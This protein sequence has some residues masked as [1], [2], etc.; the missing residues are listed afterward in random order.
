VWSVG[1]ILAPMRVEFPVVPFMLPSVGLFALRLVQLQVLYRSRV[2]CSPRER[3]GAAIAGLALSHTI[4]IAVWKGLLTRHVPFRRTPKMKAAPGLLRGLAMAHNEFFLC[5]MTLAAMVG[6]GLA[7][8]LAT[9]EAR[10]WCLVLMT[11]SL[12]YAAAVFVSVAAALPA[13]R[14]MA[15]PALQAAPRPEWQSAAAGD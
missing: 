1:L 10:L 14:R 4:A 7:H 12:P 3:L 8:H 13:R 15:L 9:L 2:P 6:V 11:Q 5:L